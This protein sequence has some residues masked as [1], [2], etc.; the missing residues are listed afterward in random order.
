[1]SVVN[2]HVSK[3]KNSFFCLEC[4]T[5]KQVA[6]VKHGT[7]CLT[8][9]YSMMTLAVESCCCFSMHSPALPEVQDVAFLLSGHI[10]AV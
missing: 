10:D 7:V 1:M 4:G 8:Y 6:P 9:L 2:M 3:N 5:R